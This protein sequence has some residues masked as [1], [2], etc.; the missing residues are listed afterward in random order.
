MAAKSITT[1]GDFFKIAGCPTG[2]LYLT[3][4]RF[5]GEAAGCPTGLFCVW[6]DRPNKQISEQSIHQWSKTKQSI[7][8]I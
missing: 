8:H 2:I 1:D 5:Q 6:F 4:Q 7:M 3:V